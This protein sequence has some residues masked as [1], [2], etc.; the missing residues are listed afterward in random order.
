VVDLR[1]L[2]KEA[3]K[4][5]REEERVSKEAEVASSSAGGEFPF[6]SRAKQRFQGIYDAERRKKAV[7]DASLLS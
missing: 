7:L 6:F 5:W 4:A 2:K 1:R 3:E